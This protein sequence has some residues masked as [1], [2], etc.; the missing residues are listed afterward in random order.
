MGILK[1]T[2][3]MVY[4]FRFLRL[5]TMSWT[6]TD[7]YKLGIIDKDGK[8]LKKVADLGKLEEKDAYTIFIRL[9]FNVKRLLEKVPLVGKSKLA[10]YA[11]AFFLIKEHTALSER[12]IKDILETYFDEDLDLETISESWFVVKEEF[13]SPGVYKLK[14]D[15][16][17]Y[18]TGDILFAK[19]SE[20]I[21]NVGCMPLDNI[22]GSNIYEMKHKQTG[23]SVYVTSH[24]IEK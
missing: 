6:D 12:Q 10:S 8:P 18:Q 7:A 21:A 13:I 22:F 23:L 20:V 24:N 1:Q 9:V 15:T 19:G 14:E 2:G 4:T 5:L 16:I 17:S 3:D 11:A